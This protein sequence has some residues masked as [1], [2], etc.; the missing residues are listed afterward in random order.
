MVIP[1]FRGMSLRTFLKRLWQEL[2]ADTATDHAAQL[3]YYFLFALF[4]FLF[5]LV[6]LAAYL[7]IEGAVDSMLSRVEYFMPDSAVSLVR[8]HMGSLL[9]EERPKLLTL[10]LL[11]AVW[12]AS[13][14]VDALRKALNLA[15][16]VPES[17]P[18]WKTQGLAILVTVVGTLLLLG[19]FAAFAVGGELGQRL[20]DRAHVGQQ[21]AALWGWLRW[22]FTASVA[23]LSFALSYYLLP[24]VKQRFRYIT[25]G[26][27]FGTGLWLGASWG[28]TLYVEQF[29]KFNVT[30]GSI[31]GVVVLLLWLYI[32]GL[33]F[34]LGGETNAII[35]HAS[36]DGKAPGTREEGEA[37]PAVVERPQPA[38]AKSA[39]AARRLRVRFWRRRTV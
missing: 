25:P 38:A 35:E 29:G 11:I 7:P 14:G 36:R 15:Y 17:R 2:E 3:S 16:G 37:P 1:G 4:P 26:S 23:L 19:S 20:A 33:A 8:D 5:F 6:T 30:Y 24:D 9:G 21:F 12:S 22:P 13:R 28:F 27:V 10:G 39:K 18:V 31:A 32:S 34:I